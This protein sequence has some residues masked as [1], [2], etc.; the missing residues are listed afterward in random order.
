M[1]T[2]ITALAFS[3]LITAPSFVQS[4]NAA[5]PMDAN[6]AKAIHE[7]SVAASKYTEH[8]WGDREIQTYRSCMA[9]HGQQE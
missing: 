5:P 9:E 1:K 6:R 8:T 2:L 4:A 7:C 3:C